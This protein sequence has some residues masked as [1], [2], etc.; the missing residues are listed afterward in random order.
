MITIIFTEVSFSPTKLFTDNPPTM[1]TWAFPT[2]WTPTAGKQAS[3]GWA[4]SLP[5]FSTWTTQYSRWLGIILN[6]H[7][8]EMLIQFSVREPLPSFWVASPKSTWAPL[9]MVFLQNHNRTNNSTF[10]HHH[11]ID[12]YS[13]LITVRTVR[14]AIQSKTMDIGRIS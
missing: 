12:F 13:E 2:R 6:C 3:T 5:A 14:E 10:L 8:S 7:F 1:W 9:P 4:S 11:H